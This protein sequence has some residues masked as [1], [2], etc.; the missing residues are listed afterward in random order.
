MKETKE[1]KIIGIAVDDLTNC[2]LNQVSERFRKS[3]ADL[4]TTVNSRYVFIA[5][6]TMIGSSYLYDAIRFAETLIESDFENFDDD[7]LECLREAVHV[8]I[9]N[10]FGNFLELAIDACLYQMK[11]EF[12]YSNEATEMRMICN[13]LAFLIPMM[14]I[15]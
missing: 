2:A 6:A 5:Q 13:L 10:E 14:S 15:L 1:N 7:E 11:D 9:N 3:T 4:K 12:K 8:S